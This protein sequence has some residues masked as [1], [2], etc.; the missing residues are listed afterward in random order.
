MEVF[1]NLIKKT[2]ITMIIISIDLPD[3]IIDYLF[4]FKLNNIKPF[5]YLMPRLFQ[6]EID[7]KSLLLK[8]LYHSIGKILV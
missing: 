4:N 3:K 1:N 8:K 7:D 6:K 5:I 2:S